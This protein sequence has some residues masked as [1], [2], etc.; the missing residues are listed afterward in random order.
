MGDETRQGQGIRTCLSPVCPQQAHIPFKT[1]TL[2]PVDICY[3]MHH[4]VT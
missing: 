3:T 4:V 1:N 2:R